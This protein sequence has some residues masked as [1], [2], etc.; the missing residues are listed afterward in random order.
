MNW[1]ETTW[2][3]KIIL[4]KLREKYNVTCLDF[5]VKHNILRNLHEL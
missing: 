3:K 5:G 4:I 2:S 1:N